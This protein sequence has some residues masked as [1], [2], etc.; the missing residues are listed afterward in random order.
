MKTY[1]TFLN[2]IVCALFF[3]ACSEMDIEP[4]LTNAKA[5]TLNALP[6][7]QVTLSQP[8]EGEN[9]L[10]CTVSWTETEFYFDNSSTPLPAGPVSYTLEIANADA[11][12]SFANAQ[13]LAVTTSLY[14]DLLTAD[15][16]KLLIEKFGVEIG[17]TFNAELRV[18][19]TYGEGLAKKVTSSNTVK[20]SATSYLEEQP[21]TA[22]TAVYICGDMNGWNNTNTD[23]MMFRDDSDPTNLTYTYT[24]KI[25][26]N[27]YYKFVSEKN[28]GTWNMYCDGGNGTLIEGDAGAFYNE[29]EGYKTIT[30]NL[31]D[32]TYTI[33]DYDVSSATVWE[34]M[35]FVGAFCN[36]GETEPDMV[37]S[38]YDPHIWSLTITLDNIEYGVKFRT[39]HSWDN[40][41]CP[42]NPDNQPYGY[43]EYNPTA[44][45]NNISI[46]DLGEYY[47]KFNDLTSHY[48]VMPKK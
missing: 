16:N 41:W 25:G 1:K 33:E 12:E 28:L 30:L 17:G 29:I 9:P 32:M 13:S 22:L 8:G 6:F 37:R 31:K 42:K 44:Q 38:E 18:V 19:A 14:A 24:G 15:I 26:S 21:P 11:E 45:D 40:R 46:K 20:F 2:I 35:N 5:S 48:I 27:C 36:W 43:A 3:S 10:L 47:V 34:N 39:G 7:Q 23:F 4:A